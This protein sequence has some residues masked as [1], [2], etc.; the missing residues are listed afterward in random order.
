M[1]DE[2][3]ER[4]EIRVDR[5]ALAVDAFRDR[6][7]PDLKVAAGRRIERREDVI[8][9]H[10]RFDLAVGEL[11]AIGQ[12]R[13]RLAL[14]DQLHVG[15][16]QQRLLPQDRMHVRS[17]R[18]VLAGDFKRRV[19]APV[20]AEL[21]RDHVAD[22]D[23]A[24]AHVRLFGQRQRAREGHGHAVALRLQR[25]RAAEGLPQEQQQPEAAEREQDDHE[26]VAQRGGALLH[27]SAT[28]PEAPTP[29]RCAPARRSASAEH[30]RVE[31]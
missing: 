5:F 25:H 28:S 26:Q 15:L 16:P 22:V 9:R 10:R 30:A 27:R 29:G 20:L 31:A 13:A 6:L 2:R 14:G 24:D 21:H 12:V 1:F 17:H 3:F 23:A 7:L 11:G 4:G 8:E 18:R 19:G